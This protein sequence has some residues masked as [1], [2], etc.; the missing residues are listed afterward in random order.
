M[1]TGKHE[2]SQ[3]SN[4]G[5]LNLF[6]FVISSNRLAFYIGCHI[7]LCHW[8]VI[9]TKAKSGPSPS[10]SLHYAQFGILNAKDIYSLRVASLAC[11]LSFSLLFFHDSIKNY[12]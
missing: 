2:Q 11:D 7:A 9:P 10:Y 12:D 6:T 1:G 3:A 5:S 8:T 4:K